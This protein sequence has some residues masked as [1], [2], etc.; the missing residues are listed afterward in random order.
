[1]HVVGAVEAFQM[2]FDL[3]DVFPWDTQIISF[4]TLLQLT[5]VVLVGT[6]FVSITGP[7][8]L[9][10]VAMSIVCVLIGTLL[11]ILDKW[12]GQLMVYNK[13]AHAESL[14][15]EN[16]SP[17]YSSD[18]N[19]GITPTFFSLLGTIF[20]AL[21]G[22]LIGSNRASVLKDP[23]RN[24]PTG[25]LLSI[26]SST[27]LY[28]IFITLFGSTF[29]NALLLDDKLCLIAV[30]FPHPLIV[31]IGI[32][33]SSLGASLQSLLTSSRILAAIATDDCVPFVKWLKPVDPSMDPRK[34]VIFTWI[35]ASS[36]TLMGKI[37]FI[38]PYVSMFVLMMYCGINISCFLVGYL[39]APGFRPSFRYFHYGTSFLGFV[40][41]LGLAYCINWLHASVGIC[42]TVFLASYIMN[43]G[44]KKN[45]GDVGQGV[46]FALGKGSLLALEARGK[47]H[48]KNW[49]PLVL[50]IIDLDAY[51]HPE[52][53][54]MMRLTAQMR[55]GYGFTLVH[56][57]IRGSILDDETF[58]RAERTRSI[59]TQIM[60]SQESDC[61]VDVSISNSRTSERI[62]FAACHSGLGPLRPNTVLLS[63][64]DDW[65]ENISRGEEFFETIKG[66][67]KLKKAVLVF[68]G[69][70]SFPSSL[71]IVQNQTIDVWWIVYDG[72]LLLLLPFILAK[73]RT[74]RSGTRLRVFAVITDLSTCA[75]QITESIKFH[76]KRIRIPA[77][78][79]SVDFTAT[80][81]RDM[82]ANNNKAQ[83]QNF[84]NVTGI[85][86]RTSHMTIDDMFSTGSSNFFSHS[87]SFAAN[88]ASDTSVGDK[89]VKIED[90][91]TTIKERSELRRDTVAHFNR[92][93]RI[94]SSEASLILTNLPVF[95]NSA[96]S[97]DFFACTEVMCN[98][99]KN[100]LFVRG[101]GEEV[102][103]TYA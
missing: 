94:Y 50:S 54:H 15:D 23:E 39:K 21:S 3:I 17:N 27:G 71:E 96:D 80:A 35:L 60:R 100:V 52:H 95:E 20:P 30:S 72:G 34:A 2:G 62:W 83:Y 31:K 47:F 51:G 59:L 64:P 41:C 90:L 74:W 8:F 9:S 65:E 48:V 18:P 45:W 33:M 4:I 44:D 37:D 91:L 101:T 7:I 73:N 25:T 49:R 86:A 61:F 84:N 56:S 6:E 102:I 99:I 58:A 16:F 87:N 76:L 36:F 79:Q 103:T 82:M 22:I 32:I 38:S 53:I 26:F 85:A 81:V 42:S 75:L 11:F 43:K 93:V 55:K 28:L 77:E 24:I 40:W 70:S 67:T 97:L 13:K 5:L 12:H 78:V 46:L 89:F 10:I 57:H 69:H 19:T 29:S 68:K 1:M 98:G 88:C 92:M 14:H 66:L 63:W